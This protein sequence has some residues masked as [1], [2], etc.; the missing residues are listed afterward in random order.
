MLFQQKAC[1]FF[2]FFCGGCGHFCLHPLFCFQELKKDI[3]SVEAFF[4]LTFM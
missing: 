4:L 2:S 1:V 3:A